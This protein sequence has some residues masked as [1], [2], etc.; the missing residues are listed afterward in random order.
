VGFSKYGERR[1]APRGRKGGDVGRRGR[2]GS[3]PER[4][5]AGGKKRQVVQSLEKKKGGGPIFLRGRGR[6]VRGVAGA[7]ETQARGERK[8]FV[9]EKKGEFRRSADPGR[10]C[11]EVRDK[12]PDNALSEKRGG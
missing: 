3:E 5:F 10:S 4:T 2:A 8:P 11:R 9:A 6:S 1:N 7:P 12:K